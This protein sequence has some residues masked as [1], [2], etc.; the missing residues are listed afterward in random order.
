MPEPV[1]F[2][3]C[4]L[5]QLA[6]SSQISS[7]IETADVRLAR[8]PLFETLTLDLIVTRGGFGEKT[9]EITVF[10]GQLATSSFNSLS[11]ILINFYL[12][13]EIRWVD[14]AF[15]SFGESHLMNTNP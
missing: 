15:M 6:E 4:V 13:T 3:G 11:F 5:I 1:S 2:N 14:V 12:I 10:E 9:K 7:K 8:V